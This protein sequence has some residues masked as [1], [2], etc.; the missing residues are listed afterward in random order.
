MG[1]ALRQ[2][3]AGVRRTPFAEC[4]RCAR[5]RIDI[6]ELGC[7]RRPEFADVHS[8]EK[9]FRHFDSGRQLLVQQQLQH[10]VV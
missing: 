9:Q 8:C 3:Q 4:R 6:V 2:F 1:A 7:L 10:L 5:L